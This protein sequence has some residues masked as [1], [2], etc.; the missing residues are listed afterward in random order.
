MSGIMGGTMGPMISVMMFTDHIQ[1]FM[2]FY[3]ILNVI[4]LIG[5]MKMWHEEIV[6]GNKEL[7]HKNIDLVSFA[8]ACII[9]T[10]VLL[11]IIIYGM[12]SPLFALG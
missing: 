12:K 1:I 11:V 10:A 8:S 6:E 3:I 9:V 2:P 5:F 7:V 4:L